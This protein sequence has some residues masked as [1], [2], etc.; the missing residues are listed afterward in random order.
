MN[1]DASSSRSTNFDDFTPID[2]LSNI[3]LP[4]DDLFTV[5]DATRIDE[6]INQT[7][8]KITQRKKKV[9]DEQ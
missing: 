9:F 6:I 4:S 1:L 8:C 3:P 2:D 7:K 5:S